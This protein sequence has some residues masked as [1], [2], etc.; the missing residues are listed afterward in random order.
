M[1]PT[2]GLENLVDALL[3]DMRIDSSKTQKYPPMNVWRNT[4]NN[5]YTIELAVAGFT[6]DEIKVEQ[7]ESK[8]V[9]TGEKAK[10]EDTSGRFYMHQQLATRYFSREFLLGEYIEVQDVSLVNG[11][12]TIR[13]FKN[14]PESK[15]PKVFTINMA[16]QKP[17][18]T[19]TKEFL[20]EGKTLY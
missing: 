19:S 10:T 11:I 6:S 1:R 4:E 7:R 12:L 13:L 17:V 3:E 18:E 5:A 14:L 16:T 2:L 20:T 8:L 9:V 15:K